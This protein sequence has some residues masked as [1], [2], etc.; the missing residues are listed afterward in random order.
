MTDLLALFNQGLAEFGARVH[1]VGADHWSDSTPCSDWDVGSLVEHLIDEQLW[2]PPLVSGHDLATADTMVKAE[3]HSLG[4]DRAAAWD[5]AALASKRAAGEP[6]ALDR[7]VELSRGPT[8]ASDYI[9]E[10]IMD[11]VVHA[12]DLGH[13][14]GYREP[15]PD[16]L[17][18][19]TLAGVQAFGDL[20][21]TGLFSPAVPVPDDASAEDRLIAFTGRDPR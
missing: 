10:M 11:A 8:P 14:I 7:Q 13:A 2:V 19:F 16:D 15:L 9:G 17:V 21:T 1:R 3:R 18:Q 12:W 5:A 4:D 6:G 20:S